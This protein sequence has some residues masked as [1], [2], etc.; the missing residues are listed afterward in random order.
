MRIDKNR[1]VADENKVL[2]RISD[3]WIAD[4]ELYLG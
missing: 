4:P 3:G 2:R 1:I